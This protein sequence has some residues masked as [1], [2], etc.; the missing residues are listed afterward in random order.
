VIV[1][2]K[3]E[4]TSLEKMISNAYGGVEWGAEKD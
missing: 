1:G 3:R 2:Q 4:K